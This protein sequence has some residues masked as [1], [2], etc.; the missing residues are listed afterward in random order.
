M[1]ENQ[2]QSVHDIEKCV[3][4]A[5]ATA[6]LALRGIAPPHDLADAIALIRG[7]AS[8]ESRNKSGSAMPMGSEPRGEN[9]EALRRALWIEAVMWFCNTRPIIEHLFIE[10][11]PLTSYR[12]RRIG[13]DPTSCLVRH[14]LDARW[15]G[16]NPPADGAAV[17]LGRFVIEVANEWWSNPLERMNWACLE[18]DGAKWTVT[19][20][21]IDE[22]EKARQSHQEAFDRARKKSA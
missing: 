22:A 2:N 12:L 17:V 9:P 11:L 4:A 20:D 18:D 19:P 7:W 13:E 16:K 6:A 3:R 10:A 14:A 5:T 15:G 8:Y 1:S 21:F